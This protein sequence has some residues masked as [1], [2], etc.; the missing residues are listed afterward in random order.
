M[1]V[2]F[3]GDQREPTIIILGRTGVQGKRQLNAKSQHQFVQIQMALKVLA[4]AKTS[5]HPL[6]ETRK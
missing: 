4:I 3:Q 2:C 6:P 5:R 1:K